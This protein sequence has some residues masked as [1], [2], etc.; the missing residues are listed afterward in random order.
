MA[1][2][3]RPVHAPVDGDVVFVLATGARPLEEPAAYQMT[4][5]GMLAADCL[6]RAIGR[7]VF[8]AEALGPWEAY[9]TRHP[10]G[11]APRT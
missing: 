7:A 6:T 9:R 1:R 2:A 3:L 11:F 4:M 10:K 8:E 5:L